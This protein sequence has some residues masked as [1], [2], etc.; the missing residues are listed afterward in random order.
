MFI[1]RELVGLGTEQWLGEE[2][3]AH[4]VIA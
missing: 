2:G 4:A 1:I 3:W